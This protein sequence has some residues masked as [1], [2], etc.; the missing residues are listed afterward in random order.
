MLSTARLSLR[1]WVESDR[2]P[3]AALSADPEVMQYYPAPL[4][5]AESDAM[6]DRIERHFD[7]H[8]YS[9]TLH[10]NPSPGEPIHPGPYRMGKGVEDAPPC[11]QP[12]VEKLVAYDRVRD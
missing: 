3:F 8:G 4:S 6:V 5:R 10:T 9:F 7:E 12:G 2:A 1:R 11:Q